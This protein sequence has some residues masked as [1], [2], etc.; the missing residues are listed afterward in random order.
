[1]NTKNFLPKA[2]LVAVL[3]AGFLFATGPAARA[4][5]DWSDSCHQ[6]LEQD[7]ARID[8]DS[9]R[10]GDHSRQVARDVDRMDATRRW[11]RDHHAE[12]DHNRFDTGL[13]IHL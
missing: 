11:C 1:M 5:R 7:R 8:H 6:K 12:W 3:G 9:A 13:Y 4:D 10:F 2:V